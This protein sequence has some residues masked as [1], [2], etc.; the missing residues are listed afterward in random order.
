[1]TTRSRS[2]HRSTKDKGSNPKHL[3]LWDLGSTRIPGPQFPL[4]YVVV[5]EEPESADTKSGYGKQQ[6]SGG[7]KLSLGL[8]GPKPE[9]GGQRPESAPVWQARKQRG[10]KQEDAP[11]PPTCQWEPFSQ[12]PV[13]AC[14]RGAG[15]RPLERKRKMPSGKLFSILRTN[16]ER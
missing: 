4:L 3:Q 14:G 12:N 13:G 9:K 6:G 16:S 1:M 10:G 8:R 7:R 2:R 11:R 15:S 5:G